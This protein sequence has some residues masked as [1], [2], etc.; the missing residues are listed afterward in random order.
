MFVWKDENKQK[1]TKDGHLKIKNSL[2]LYYSQLNDVRLGKSRY[3]TLNLPPSKLIKG[4]ANNYFKLSIPGKVMYSRWLDRRLLPSLDALKCLDPL[5]LHAASGRGGVG[6]LPLAWEVGIR[7]R[8][9]DVAATAATTHVDLRREHLLLQREEILMSYVRPTI[10]I[11]LII[12]IWKNNC[13]LILEQS[14][15]HCHKQMS[16]Q[17]SVEKSRY[18]KIC[19]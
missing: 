4:F 1:G 12:F 6:Q 14:S 16:L 5:R 9:A 15:S 13:L 19:F 3:N 10:Q 8:D 17:C 2:G 7:T 18:S 11:D